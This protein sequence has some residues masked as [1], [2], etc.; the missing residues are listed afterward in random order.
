M[1]KHIRQLLSNFLNREFTLQLNDE[2]S[3]S[4]KKIMV[5]HRHEQ[6]YNNTKETINPEIYKKMQFGAHL[7][8][9]HTDTFST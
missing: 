8:T 2:N 1:K 9:S 5:D 7:A 4:L 6:F 3:F